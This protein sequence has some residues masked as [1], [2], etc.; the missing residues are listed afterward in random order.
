MQILAITWI[1]FRNIILCEK[2]KHKDRVLYGFIYMKCPERRIYRDRKQVTAAE[3]SGERR[4][5]RITSDGMRGL[6][7]VK[8]MLYNS[9]N[10]LKRITELYT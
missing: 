9:V 5:E 6:I 2:A 10:L 3:G 8:E 1:I 7:G 4:V